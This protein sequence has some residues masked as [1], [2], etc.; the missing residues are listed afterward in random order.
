MMD[1]FIGTTLSKVLCCQG[2][3]LDTSKKVLKWLAE[4][5]L[6]E[7]ASNRAQKEAEE[8]A[9]EERRQE[10][11]EEKKKACGAERKRFRDEVSSRPAGQHRAV[12]N[13][14]RA[15]VW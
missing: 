8:V 5:K 4:D 6:P 9:E 3:E 10:A 13:L 14:G 2:A 7:R 11:I 1:R 12:D 15:W